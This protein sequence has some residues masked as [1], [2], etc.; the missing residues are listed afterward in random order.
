MTERSTKRYSY[1]GDEAKASHFLFYFFIV[2]QN[3]PLSL[4]TRHDLSINTIKL[5]CVQIYLQ[6][7]A[8]FNQTCAQRKESYSDLR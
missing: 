8:T 3:F 6:Q 5:Q 1:I 4:L 7:N 2:L